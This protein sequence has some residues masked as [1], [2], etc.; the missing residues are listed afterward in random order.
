MA[1]TDGSSFGKGI[2][3]KGG[4]AVVYV[5]KS[6]VHFATVTRE[7]MGFCIS[8]IDAELR[9]ITLAVEEAPSHMDEEQS[10][11][12][13]IC[14]DCRSAIQIVINRHRAVAYHKELGRLRQGLTVLRNRHVNVKIAWIPGHVDFVFNDAADHAAKLAASE[15]DLPEELLE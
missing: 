2:Q 8:N 9:G 5:P 15:C 6:G 12:L 4:G 13:I 10:A 7:S 11:D 14:C 1:F 3:A